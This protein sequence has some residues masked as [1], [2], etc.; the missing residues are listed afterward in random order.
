M[1]TALLNKI[2]ANVNRPK[3]LVIM[4]IEMAMT[5]LFNQSPD[6]GYDRDSMYVCR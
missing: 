4:M 3:I 6:D 1:D 2:R 5:A